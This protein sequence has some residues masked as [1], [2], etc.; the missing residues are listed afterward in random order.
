VKKIFSLLIILSFLLASFPVSA[1]DDNY[2]VV[3]AYYSPLPDQEYYITGNYKDELILNGKGIAWASGKPVFSGM[4]AA[5][6]KYSFGTKIYLDGLGIWVVEDRGGAIVPAGQRGYSYDRID[7]WMGYGDEGLLRANFWGKRKV[8]GYTIDNQNA[9]TLDYYDVPA[10]KWATTGLQKTGFSHKIDSI[11]ELQKVSNIFDVSLGRWSDAVLITEMQDIFIELGY[12]YG[13][14]WKYDSA[15]I[16][17]VYDF[18]IKHEIVSSEYELWAWSYGPKTR[19]KLKD[20]YLP[21]VEEKERQE[22]FLKNITEIQESSQAKA[23][24]Y[25]ENIGIPKYW[26]VSY[27]VR[28]LQNILIGFWYFDYKD[29]ARFWSITQTAIIDYQIDKGIISSKDE[30]WTGHFGP[31]TREQITQNLYEQYFTE[32]LNEN[33]L[34]EAYNEYIDADLKI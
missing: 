24:Q 6:G 32:S 21:Y 26:D 31:K 11:P 17:A 18:Q 27:E 19:A 33:E 10:P 5:P 8:Y 22:E 28:E 30:I 16:S 23:E 7:V 29:T 20:I 15:T 13:N 4:L 12:L 3:T 34:L 25:L 1:Q 2:F 9:T 14:S